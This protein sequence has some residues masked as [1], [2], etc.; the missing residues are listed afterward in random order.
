M[1]ELQQTASSRKNKLKRFLVIGGILLLAGGITAF[2]IWRDKI[3]S[4]TS[5]EAIIIALAGIFLGGIA[6]AVIGDIYTKSKNWFT[7]S[8]SYIAVVASK[9]SVDF[10]IPEEFLRGFDD[11]FP[12]GRTY[13]ETR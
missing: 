13:I 4:I 6:R 11:E 8:Y 12:G 5:K 10:P 2:I 7:R 9:K 3:L 1:N